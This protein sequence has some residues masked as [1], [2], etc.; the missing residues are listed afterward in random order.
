MGKKIAPRRSPKQE[1]GQQRVDRILDAAA[2]EFARVGYEVATT[3]AIARRAK[4]SVGSVYQ[5]YPN[6]EA[7][8]YALSNRY[9]ELL[10]GLHDRVLGEQTNE[11]S[12]PEFY[13]RLVDGIAEFHRSQP[14]F[15]AL[16]YGSTTSPHLAAAAGVLHR[17]CMARAEQTVAARLPTL[18]EE[19]VRMYAAINV[20]VVKSLLPLSET[21]DEAFRARVLEEIKKLLL[22]YMA[23]VER[24][25]TGRST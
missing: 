2:V 15:A 20:E 22:T 17:E 19:E 21:G 11:L 1:R 9:L 5:F 10:R 16:F 18:P 14:G 3:N 23:G 8:L 12:M 7:I 13:D 6:K 24:E 25:V 4:T